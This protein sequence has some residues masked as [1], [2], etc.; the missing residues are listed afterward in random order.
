[1]SDLRNHLFSTLEALQDPD[2]P[3]DIERARAVS[4]VAQTI[5]NTAKVEIDFMKAMGTDDLGE[6]FVSADAERRK[7]PGPLP[8]PRMIGNGGSR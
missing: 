7:L 1:M 2:K 3:M 5:I 8:G 6:F 4:E